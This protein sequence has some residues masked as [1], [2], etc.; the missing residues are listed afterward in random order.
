MGNGSSTVLAI[1]RQGWTSGPRRWPATA[2]RSRSCTTSFDETAGQFSP[3]GRWVAYQSNESKP[4]QIFIQP[5]PGPGGPRQVTTAGGSQPRWRP[6]GKEL[7]YVGLDGRLMAVPIAVGAD[8][9]LETGTAVA[10]F[11]DAARHRC[12]SNS[13]GLGSSAQ[14]AVA[15]DG[16][17]LMTMT[18]E[19]ATATPITVVLNWDA[20]L[21]K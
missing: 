4:V 17:F 13:G 14:Y 3:D 1:R 7:F 6:D 8:R 10:L 11:Q 21:K 2:S 15:P 16:R 12:D 5:F 20:A 19:A 18:L 9:Q